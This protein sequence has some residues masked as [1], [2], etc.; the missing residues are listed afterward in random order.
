MARY[1]EGV[2]DNSYLL[3]LTLTITLPLMPQPTATATPS[4]SSASDWSR[5]A[6][7]APTLTSSPEPEPASTWTAASA[8]GISTNKDPSV[9]ALCAAAVV[10]SIALVAFVVLA[11]IGCVARRRHHLRMRN[12]S[13]ASERLPP[14]TF[15]VRS[16]GGAAEP[17]SESGTK[18]SGAER[19]SVMPRGAAQAFSFD[20]SVLHI[21]PD[22]PC[23]R[24]THTLNALPYVSRMTTP[25]SQ[26]TARSSRRATVGGTRRERERDT[27][28]PKS[29]R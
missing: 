10:S 12:N 21:R 20:G 15:H 11:T 1:D 23:S 9:A 28:G 22:S 19:E 18:D 29:P 25:S 16:H 4:F 13:S 3:T 8:I 5:D 24:Y 2:V 14:L 6:L 26:P 7:P 27:G 17:E